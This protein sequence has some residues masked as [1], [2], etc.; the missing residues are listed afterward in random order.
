M[1]PLFDLLREGAPDL[2]RISVRY[3]K[4]FYDRICSHSVHEVVEVA[5]AVQV[6]QQAV[7]QVIPASL[8][9]KTGRTG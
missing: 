3:H 9:S 4:A 1:P 6:G 2:G 5:A 8:P 7:F